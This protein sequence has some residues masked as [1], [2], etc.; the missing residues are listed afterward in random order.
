MKP[1]RRAH[2]PT[3]MWPALLLL[4]LPACGGPIE[5]LR[6]EL[7]ANPNP[8]VP[9]A[10]V[11]H[12]ETNRPVRAHLTVSSPDRTWQVE[13]DEAFQASQS[14]PVLGLLPDSAHSVSVRLESADGDIL[15]VDAG[16]LRTDP[17]PDD[18]PPIEVRIARP[19]LMEPGVTVIPFLRWKNFAL[20]RKYGLIVA[21]DQRADVVW[22]YRA[23]HSINTV[24]RL[25]NGNL[26]YLAGSHGDLV[27]IDM[28]G[29]RLRRWHTLG[30][31]KA[32]PESSTPVVSDTFHHELIE[33]PSGNFLTL[34]T[35]V[36]DFAEYPTSYLDPNAPRTPAHVVG[37]VL[38]EFAPDG[39]I[40]R[41]WKLLD[42]L[43][44]RRA[45]FASLF[46]GLWAQAYKHRLRQRA[47]DWSHSNSIDLSPDGDTA[48]IS[49]F[50]QEV[51]VQID[52]ES[53][54]ID[55]LLGD[56]R[57]WQEPWKSLFLRPEGE[58]TWPRGTHG[59]GF[60]PDGNLLFYDNGVFV[61]DADSGEV[62]LKGDS[63][64]RAVE[65]R[66]DP[67]ART[68]REVWTYGGP[69][70]EAYFSPF[71]CDTAY[72]PATGNVLVTDGGRVQAADGQPSAEIGGGHHW[73]R[74]VQVTREQPARK[75]FEV[76]TRQRDVGW[77]IYRATHFPS[78]NP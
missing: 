46:P 16:E 4:G 31:P 6:V 47:C 28:L 65:V 53:G 70:D 35:E 61:P 26:A 23:R 7:V 57:G 51:I 12:L 45:T 15:E 41:Q 33:L 30:T 76:V 13:A 22:Y 8:A 78:L 71:L 34:S 55:W 10:G 50:H 75:V 25:N 52:L 73:A 66:I 40:V 36:R 27:E 77:A 74:V 19:G 43:D 21:L 64:S 56:P 68:F 72:L 59:A 42:L 17:L 24:V 9:L 32:T 60:T 2:R 14:L 38:L 11:L 63:L 5:A 62:V 20:D 29:N 18:F 39:K 49:S 69:G 37:D 54:T 3:A 48:V 44:P 1:T 67:D 58:F